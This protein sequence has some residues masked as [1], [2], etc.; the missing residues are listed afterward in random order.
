VLPDLTGFAAFLAEAKP[1][2]SEPART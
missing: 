1:A 2:L